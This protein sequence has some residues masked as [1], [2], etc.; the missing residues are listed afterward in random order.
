MKK[1]PRT[2]KNSTRYNRRRQVRTEPVKRHGNAAKWMAQFG[3]VLGLVLAAGLAF[4]WFQ[5]ST[6]QLQQKVRHKRQRLNIRSK[7]IRNLTMELARYR[8]GDYIMNQIKRRDMGLRPPEPGQVRYITIKD[9]PEKSRDNGFSELTARY[10]R[11]NDWS[12]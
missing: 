7:K 9:L 10:L 4:V 8:S 2:A 3:A 6:Q 1:Q 12:K 5:S 11:R